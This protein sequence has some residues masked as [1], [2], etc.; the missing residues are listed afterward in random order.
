MAGKNTFQN[1]DNII[2]KPQI[3]KNPLVNKKK[4]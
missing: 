1:T 4:W 3:P 2:K